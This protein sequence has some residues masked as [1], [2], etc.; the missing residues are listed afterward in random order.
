M[1]RALLSLGSNSGDRATQIRRALDE[2]AHHSTLTRASHIYE[3]PS[4][5]GIGPDYMNMVVEVTTELDEPRLNAIAKDIEH[6]LGRDT[7]KKHQPIVPIDI[8]VV[9]VNEKIIRPSDFNRQ[10]FV[11]GYKNLTSVSVNALTIDEKKS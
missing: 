7:S 8:D 3:T 11:I 1:I 5:N 9:V 6:R 2:L 4:C 10:Y